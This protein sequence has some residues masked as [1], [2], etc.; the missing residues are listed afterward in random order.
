M[1]T[2]RILGLEDERKVS[3]ERGYKKEYFVENV[4]WGSDLASVVDDD[5]SSQFEGLSVA[6][7]EPDRWYGDDVSDEDNDGEDRVSHSKPVLD[8]WI[9]RD[10]FYSRSNSSIESRLPPRL[11]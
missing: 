11:K 9:Y 2:V 10:T 5:E 1:A 4:K 7:D 6:H 3:K 8:P